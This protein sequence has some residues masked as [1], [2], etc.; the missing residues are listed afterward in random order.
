[1][2]SLNNL[3]AA[4]LLYAYMWIFVISSGAWMTLTTLATGNSQAL[5]LRE[6]AERRMSSAE[7]ARAKEMA[8][9][10]KPSSK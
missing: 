7:I 2:D 8:A 10:F 3:Q 5:Q 4:G 6:M 1:M 9:S